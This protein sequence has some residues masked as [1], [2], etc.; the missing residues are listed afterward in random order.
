MIF[1]TLS[2]FKYQKTLA[3]IIFMSVAAVCLL[4]FVTTPV[5][6][7]VGIVV[8]QILGNPYKEVSHY[9]I[10][11]LLK[12][13]V[14]GLGFGMRVSS[15]LAAGKNGFFFTVG[16]IGITLSLGLLI[17]KLFG[18]DKK[19]S[20]LISSGTA[21][22]G[23]SAIAAISPIIKADGKQISVAIG[24][25]FLLNSVALFL[26][27]VI[28]HFFALSQQQFGIWCAIAIHDTSSVVG[29]ADVYG[30]RA[31]EIATTVKLARA[32]W[33]LPVSVAFALFSH[34]SAK[35]IKIPYF[36]GLFIFAIIVNTYVPGVEVVAPYIV[37]CAKIALTLT[38]FLIG[39][40]LTFKS[41]KA[42][43]IKPLLQA[44]IVWAF[45]SIASLAII[46][47]TIN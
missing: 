17:G 3:K 18:I 20:Q 16:S 35:N 14:V 9:A 4:P 39:S 6:L 12:I 42:V 10:N 41:L 23:G 7:A 32:L 2:L 33:I 19:I 47:Q 46:M 40:T 44:I 26:F 30:P 21:I 22:C 15:A 11:W 37:K 45:I 38:L 29:A 1:R 24:I 34:G 27:P 13:A 5:A 31:L 28:G 8:A 25:V 36:I 43:G